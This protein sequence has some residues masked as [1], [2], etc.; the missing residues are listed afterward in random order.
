MWPVG[1]PSKPSKHLDQEY[2]T[3]LTQNS[4]EDKRHKQLLADF[5]EMLSFDMCHVR[6]RLGNPACQ[7]YS[8]VTAFA[9]HL[10]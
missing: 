7:I 1:K 6:T 5:I 8:K 10:R 2:P 9:T 4:L 3:H